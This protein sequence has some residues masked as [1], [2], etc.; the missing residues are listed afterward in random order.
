MIAV[1]I[2]TVCFFRRDLFTCVQ[3]EHTQIRVF[4]PDRE[5]SVGSRCTEQIFPV[6]G[7]TGEQDA[8][9][10]CFRLKDRV[11]NRTERPA[12]WVEGDAAK[13]IAEVAQLAW[14][15]QCRGGTE[16][17]L[18]PIRRKGWERFKTAFREQS[19]RCDNFLFLHVVDDYIRCLVIYFRTVHWMRVLR[20]I[21]DGKSNKLSGRMPGRINQGRDRLVGFRIER[22][23]PVA[24]H[25]YGAAILCTDMEQHFIRIL[26]AKRM[27]VHA[28]II[29]QAVFQNR[30][31][32]ERG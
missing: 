14:N 1:G 32:I 26:H 24:I 3:V 22:L 4:M 27:T 2:G 7:D 15:F 20:R 28:I 30:F 25:Q 8:S 11:D 31:L 16:I 5:R 10:F 29:R 19:L 17:K 12:F 6:R 23:H 21:V 18:L 13:T 9:P